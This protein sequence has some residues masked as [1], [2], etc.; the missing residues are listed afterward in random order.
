MSNNWPE[1]LGDTVEK[2]AAT[3]RNYG[4]KG[5]RHNPRLCPIAASYQAVT[6]RYAV[7][8]VLIQWPDDIKS[9]DRLIDIEVDRVQLDIPYVNR[10]ALANFALRFDKNEFP[11]LKVF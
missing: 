4:V 11:D 10:L 5:Y 8:V 7:V 2:I 3:L 6:N 9:P 1:C